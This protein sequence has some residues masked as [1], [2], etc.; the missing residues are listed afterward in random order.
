MADTPEK[1][2]KPPGWSHTL[3][4]EAS[5]PDTPEVEET[6]ASMEELREQVE[7]AAETPPGQGPGE[8]GGKPASAAAATAA[9]GSGRSAAGSAS[10]GLAG[11]LLVLV[12]AGG[13]YL[14]WPLWAPSLP[15][16]LRGTLAPVMEAGRGTEAD[17]KIEA[18]DSRIKAVEG[19]IQT[20]RKQ[21]E[22]RGA[23][24]GLKPWAEVAALNKRLEAVGAENASRRAALAARIAALESKP[25][26]TSVPGAAPVS[27]TVP[28]E[29]SAALDALRDDNR[30]LADQ[31]AVLAG[32]LAASGA[33]PRLSPATPSA[34][35]LMLAVGQLREVMRGTGAYVRE[36]DAV[37]GL[38]GD[39]PVIQPELEVLAPRARLG[40]PNLAVLQAEFDAVAARIVRAALAPQG[41]G[42]IER[43]MARLARVVTVRR[44]GAEAAAGTGPTA[45][46][47]KA[48]LRLAA[49]DLAGAVAALERLKGAPA[50]A[51]RD[52]IAG[53]WA[54][55]NAEAA[56]SSLTARAIATLGGAAP[57]SP[58][59]GDGADK[60]ADRPGG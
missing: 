27:R 17:R 29:Y 21:L 13:A 8:G 9:A 42:W 4:E 38:A 53:A 20:L 52:W 2:R 55:L 15:G 30:R 39:D 48:E 12:V 10:W 23:P 34:G 49:R 60:G 51:A 14:S 47:A 58:K 3:R 11:M 28:A 36:L 37:R 7:A 24:E 56:L 35:A 59:A 40:T 33:A 32:K 45:L 44:T 26:P 50:D 46:V 57:A 18:L 22:A 16:W 19:D 31:V 5:D 25:Q 1:D 54:R 41:S 6:S 43:T